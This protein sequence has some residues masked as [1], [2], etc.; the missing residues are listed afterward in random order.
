MA[1]ATGKRVKHVTS[2]S[3]NPK[4]TT[5]TSASTSTLGVPKPFEYAPASLRPLTSTL[6]TDH[7]Y[8]V[9]LDHTPVELKKRVFVVPILLNLVI[10]VGLCL[11]VY[12]AT[13][14]YI[15]QIITIFGYD[16]PYKVDT[17]N[18]S[19]GELINTLSSRFFLFMLDYF[20]FVIIGSWPREFVFGSKTLRFTGPF[21][22]RR[23][24]GFQET[25]IIVRRGRRWDTPLLDTGIPD[26]TKTWKVDE[27]LT[28]NVKVE[29]AMR[30][31]YLAKTGYLLLDR[32]WDLD[33]KA[34]LDAHK[35]VDQ[36]TL[37][38][39]DLDNLALVYYQKHWL[40]WRVHEAPVISAKDAASDSM[41]ET[42]RNKLVE[43]GAE[44]VFYR[45]I[46]IVQYETS[47]PGGFNEGRQ[48][49]AMQELRTLLKSRG[50]DDV[51]FWEDIGGKAG[52][53]GFSS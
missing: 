51:Q 39:K 16:T 20:I 6:S 23:T 53:P 37:K 11:R 26:V 19:A 17:S 34:I 5:G 42:F 40:V 22:W 48:A 3:T 30:T 47:R 12:Y 43:L 13:P 29:A 32:D 21:Q 14:I 7:F 33:F 46:E 27:E 10:V 45:W 15:Q 38:S 52:L 36:G 44:D 25:E 8:L 31:T 24:L 1:R 50:L 2:A 41:L 35:L 28:I 4:S 18:A 9:H 49:E